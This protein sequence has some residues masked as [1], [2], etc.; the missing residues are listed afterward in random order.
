MV[1]ELKIG[2]V[3]QHYKGQKYIVH[4]VVKHSET[5]ESFVMY[6]CLYENPEGKWWVR[7]LAMFLE[8][9]EMDGKKLPRFA[10]I[11]DQRPKIGL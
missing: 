2:G 4:H 1:K 9:V 7:P 5:L 10:Y 6:E 3:Y 8:E 11:S